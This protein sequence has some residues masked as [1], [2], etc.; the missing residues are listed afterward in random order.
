MLTG[1]RKSYLSRLTVFSAMLNGGLPSDRRDSGLRSTIEKPTR[2][3]VPT[4]AK[5]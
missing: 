5:V 1:F 2:G 3:F 4:Q